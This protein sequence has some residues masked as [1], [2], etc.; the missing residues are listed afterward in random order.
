MPKSGMEML[1]GAMGVDP[2]EVR[3]NI[4]DFMT[5]MKATAVKVSE[6]QDRIEAKLD[7][8]LDRLETISPK[9]ST[10]ELIEDGK[11]T[12]VLVTDERFP[13]AMLKDAGMEA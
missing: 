6:N 11:A 3:A 12:G 2:T 1:L 10:Q 4:E 7:E 13:A 5:A 9:P 8:I